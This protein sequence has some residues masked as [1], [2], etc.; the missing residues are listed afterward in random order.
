MQVLVMLIRFL[1]NL[2][3]ISKDVQQITIQGGEP[4]IME[5]YEYYFDLL[6][7]GNIAKNIDLHVITNATNVNK[8]FYKILK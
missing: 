2:Y 7:K 6:D 4:S 3:S 1:D 5:E 8:K